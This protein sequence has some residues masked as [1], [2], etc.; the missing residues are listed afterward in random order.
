MDKTHCPKETSISLLWET[1]L[2]TVGKEYS[3]KL[4]DL[5]TSYLML[6]PHGIG[7]ALIRHIVAQP[8]QEG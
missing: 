1:D 8:G 5:T 7:Q 6:T 4:V 2:Q 3:G